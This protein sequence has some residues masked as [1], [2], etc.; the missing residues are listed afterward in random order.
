MKVEENWE[1]LELN[2]TRQLLFPADNVD[3]LDENINTVKKLT[4]AVL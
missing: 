1:G 3:I 4:Q 2:G